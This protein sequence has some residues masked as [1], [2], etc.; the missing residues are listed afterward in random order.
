VNYL[1]ISTIVRNEHLYI[2]EWVSFHLKQGIQHF[3]LFDNSEPGEMDQKAPVREYEK[4]ITW[5]ELP[6]IAQ[7]RSSVN[8]TV[9]TYKHDTVWCA[10]IDVD[11]FL[12]SVPDKDL[13]DRLALYSDASGLCV[14]WLLFGSGGR[15]FYSPAP[16]TSRFIMRAKEVNPHVKSI[17]KL[18]ETYGMGSNV[19]TFHAQDVI[20]DENYS[21]MPREYATYSPATAEILRINHYVTKSKE[22]CTERR[23]MRRADTGEI[24]G[25]DFFEAHDR[26]DVKD[27][28]ILE[29]V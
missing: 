5:H 11:E 7:Q 15:E 20:V 29:K 27:E 22:E 9:D 4:Y 3:Y 21:V 24:R 23:K 6:G 18:S 2:K 8:H 17:M 28:S 13:K 25:D 10:F 1:S 26:N 19:H 16:V 12:Y 14:H